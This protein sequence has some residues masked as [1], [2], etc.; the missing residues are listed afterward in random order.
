MPVLLDTT[1]ASLLHPKKKGTEQRQRYDPHLRNQ[2]LVLSFQTVA[3]LLQWADENNWGK[4]ERS[5]LDAF[6]ARSVVVPSD[7][8]LSRV[9]AH[10]MTRCRS[11]GRRLEAGDAWIAATAI[12]RRIPLLTHDR[13]FVD[14]PLADL[15][16]VCY[17]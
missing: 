14:L 13:D 6:I 16:V 7:H 1:I 5:N 2:L 3:E 9:W 15:K 8:E 12:H 17:A 10:V 11:R 4:R